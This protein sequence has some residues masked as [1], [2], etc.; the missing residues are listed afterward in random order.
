MESSSS[1]RSVATEFEEV[2]LCS[3]CGDRQTAK[4]RNFE[5]MTGWDSLDDLQ[6]RLREGAPSP[7]Q[8]RF[9]QIA[10]LL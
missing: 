1:S 2:Q 4:R 8:V 6:R 5:E 7:W 9:I 10:S 3:R